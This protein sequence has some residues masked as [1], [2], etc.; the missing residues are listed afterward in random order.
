[1]QIHNPYFWQVVF[2]DREPEK[3]VF[4]TVA[5]N[6]EQP[7]YTASLVLDPFARQK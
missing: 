5:P 2:I 3:A 1:M 4:F 7:E 6:K